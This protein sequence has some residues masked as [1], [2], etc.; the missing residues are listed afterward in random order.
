MEGEVLSSLEWFVKVA[1]VVVVVVV[2]VVVLSVVA[3]SEKQM[4]VCL[5][6]VT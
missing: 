1:A 4:C 2:V 5:Q 6:L 3:V